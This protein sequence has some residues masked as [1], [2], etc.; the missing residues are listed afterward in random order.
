MGTVTA[1]QCQFHHNVVGPGNGGAM[2]VIGGSTF[3][4]TDCNLRGNM[5]QSSGGALYIVHVGKATISSSFQTNIANKKHGGAIF[6]DY[7]GH[8]ELSGSQF[9]TNRARLSGGA[10]FVEEGEFIAGNDL[11]FESNE[12]SMVHGGGMSVEAVSSISLN[13]SEFTTNYARAGGGALWIHELP[14]HA[15][16]F[17]L[18]LVKFVKNE[19]DGPGGAILLQGS[20]D[21]QA[22][23]N[24]IA[25]AADNSR[26]PPVTLRMSHVTFTGNKAHIGGGVHAAEGVQLIILCF[27]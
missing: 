21:A 4:I 23:G 15:M 14:P 22:T 11:V 20:L 7:L 13:T 5:V 9:R 18:S 10:V 12:A 1:R 26:V 6:A 2:T 17:D 24:N 27:E 19:A 25:S 3:A 16:D 8:L